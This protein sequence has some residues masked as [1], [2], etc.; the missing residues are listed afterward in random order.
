MPANAFDILDER[1]L[2]SAV[3]D[4]GAL[5]RAL[6]RPLTFYVGLDPSAASLTAGHLVPLMLA[7][8]PT[9]QASCSCRGS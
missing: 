6:E 9:P 7:T 1:G 3:S 5:R 4:A 2:I 8:T